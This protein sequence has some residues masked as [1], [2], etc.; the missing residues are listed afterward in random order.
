[1]IDSPLKLPFTKRFNGSDG[2]GVQKTQ[3]REEF[4]FGIFGKN[5]DSFFSKIILLN[6][7]FLP[8]FYKIYIKKDGVFYPNCILR[9]RKFI[10]M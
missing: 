7:D 6:F 5:F 1:M 4:G 10:F 8:P 9:I 2:K 3:Q